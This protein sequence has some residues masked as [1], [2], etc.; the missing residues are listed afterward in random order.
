M[1]LLFLSSIAGFL[2][3]VFGVFGF[4]AIAPNDA[5]VLLLFGEYKGSVRE[6]GFF[7]VNPFYSK[8]RSRCAS[9][10]SRPAR[11]TPRR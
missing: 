8:R 3:A 11:A 7:W 2:A 1:F 4:L 9:A 10:T 6:S 5:R